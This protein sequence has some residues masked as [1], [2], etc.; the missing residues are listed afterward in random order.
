[1]H[2]PQRFS[3]MARHSIYAGQVESP[4]YG[5]STRGDFELRS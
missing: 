4:E 2:S 5:M 1:M 3:Q